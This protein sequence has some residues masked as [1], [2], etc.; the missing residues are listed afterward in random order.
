MTRTIASAGRESRLAVVAVA[1]PVTGPLR[2]RPGT[3][4]TC[5]RIPWCA[6]AG[7]TAT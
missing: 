5:G 2:D 3:T 7:C 1:G 4:G 6:A